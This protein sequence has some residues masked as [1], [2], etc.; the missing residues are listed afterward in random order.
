MRCND[1]PVS[2]TIMNS[3][4]EQPLKGLK[5]IDTVYLISSCPNK[6]STAYVVVQMWC[7]SW[8]ANRFLDSLNILQF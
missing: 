2:T 6:N 1:G 5:K 8:H 4:S 7:G 3:K